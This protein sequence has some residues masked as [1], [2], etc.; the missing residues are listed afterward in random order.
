MENTNN[1]EESLPT[2]LSWMKYLKQ[3]RD[4]KAC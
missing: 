2:V 3:Q 4:G 1:S